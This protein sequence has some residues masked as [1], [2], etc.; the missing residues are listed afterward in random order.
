[1]HADCYSYDYGIIVMV[2]YD[3]NS[4]YDDD[5]YGYH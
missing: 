5:Y 2:E 4:E 3:Y 1:M